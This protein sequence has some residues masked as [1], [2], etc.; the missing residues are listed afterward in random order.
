MFDLLDPY[1]VD[2]DDDTRHDDGDTV[3]EVLDAWAQE[4]QAN[5]EALCEESEREAQEQ[6]RAEYEAR[7]A[8]EDDL[9]ERCS[10]TAN[11]DILYSSGI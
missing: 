7:W 10:G 5:L 9:W 8:I 4:S 6:A 2:F 1:F 3:D 11:A